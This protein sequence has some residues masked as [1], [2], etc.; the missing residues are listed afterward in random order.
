MGIHT[1]DAMIEAAPIEP[2]QT[3][4]S[5]WLAATTN[6]PDP[7]HVRAR[8]GLVTQVQSESNPYINAPCCIM[9]KFYAAKE[10]FYAEM[11]CIEFPVQGLCR[12]G[13]TV[14]ILAYHK[15]KF[16]ANCFS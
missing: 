15:G 14:P 9:A 2:S 10:S 1:G 6:T 3:A 16:Y 11:F 5:S 13:S 7:T 4:M 12:K 8:E